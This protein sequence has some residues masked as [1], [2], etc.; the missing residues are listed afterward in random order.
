MANTYIAVAKLSFSNTFI[1]TNRSLF[2]KSHILFIS[3]AVAIS[4][5]ATTIKA[6]AVNTTDSLALVDFYTSTNGPQW[7]NNANWLT[8]MPVSEWYGVRISDTRVTRLKLH[9]NKLGGTLPSSIGN[10]TMLEQLVLY[11]NNIS[12]AIPSSIGN[13]I[14]LTFLSLQVNQFTDT[15][16]ASIGNLTKL[17][18]LQLN[19]NKL[20]GCIPSSIGNLSSLN[21]LQLYTNLLT[22][23]IPSSIG[24][25]TAIRSIILSSNL[26]SGEIPKSFRRLTMLQY[27]FIHHNNLTTTGNDFP[28]Y[29]PPNN[30]EVA[31]EYNRFTFDG[32]EQ[33]AVKIYPF[34]YAPQAPIDIHQN[35]NNLSVY[36]GGTL[37]NNTYTWYGVGQTGNTVITG[38]ST[39]TPTASGMYYAKVANSMVRDLTL[40][41]DTVL[42]TAP[43]A[44]TEAGSQ[45]LF[46]YPNPAKDAITVN[47]LNAKRTNKVTVTDYIGHVW[48]NV[49]A[50]QQAT[51]TLN[52]SKLQPGNYV[53]NVTDGNTISTVKFVKE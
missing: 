31:A 4:I 2:M 18:I 9:N 17:V 35:G 30:L 12:G 25:L 23:N 42:Y 32:I 7:K 43:L 36:A 33:L 51:A 11:T 44:K 5:N 13:L 40:T 1:R 16:P 53:V 52:I 39:F 8:A 37:Q 3:L 46:V 28:V 48:L 24:N 21:E 41:T 10:L 47:G 20:T 34:T 22:G 27:F 49:V 19:D 26:L 6:Q 38:D 45:K 14:N 15:I 50:N 29:N